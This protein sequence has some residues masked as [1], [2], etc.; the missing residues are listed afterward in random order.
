MFFDVISDFC[1]CQQTAKLSQEKG[2][3]CICKHVLAAKL[4]KAMEK[5]GL[6]EVKIIEDTDYA[7]LLLS[8]KAH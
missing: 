7:P 8:S 5:Q 6:L 2:S 3:Q 1:F 4:A